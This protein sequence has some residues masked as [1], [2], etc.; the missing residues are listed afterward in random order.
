M[1]QMDPA[2]VGAGSAER[3]RLLHQVKLLLALDAMLQEGSVSGAAAKLDM[4]TSAM[5]RLLAELRDFY[6][7]RIFVR[8][9][10][11]MVPTPLAES[12]RLRVRALAG[13]AQQLLDQATHKAVSLDTALAHDWLKASALP[14]PVL[15]VRPADALDGAPTPAI[16]SRRLAAIGDDAQPLRRLGKYVA[17][18]A[19]G[20][21]GRRPLTL[22]EARDALGIILAGEADP[23]QIGALL[24]TIQYRGVTA[25]ELAGFVEAIREAMPPLGAANAKVPP[26]GA[27]NAKVQPPGAANA[28]VPRIGAGSGKLPA[29][30]AADAACVD[31]DWPA[32]LSPN[33]RHTP[34]FMH[35]ARLVAAAG[36]RVL[37]HGHFGQGKESGKLELAASD[38]GIPVCLT[39]GEAQAAL[40]GGKLA[41]MPMSVFAAQTQGL[42]G[43]YNVLSTR[44]PISQAVHLINP[45]RAK[46][47]LLGAA[48]I[49]R[50][51]FYRDVA[52][53]LKMDNLAVVGSTRDFAQ[54]SPTRAAPIYR[55]ASGTDVDFVVP[56][57]RHISE[58]PR[59]LF[60][61]R[62]YWHALWEGRVRDAQVEATII[63]TAAVALLC[64]RGDPEARFEDA[65]AQAEG[66]WNDRLEQVRL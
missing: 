29:V 54:L 45:L 18:V 60:T 53:L 40:T 24:M 46:A 21:G 13:E 25:P 41:Y 63:H 36:Y 7:D 28:K 2:L 15:A 16:A 11:G 22:E 32:Y 59:D 58:G 14:P 5:S 4:Q 42:L 33:W 12:L 57:V 9:G 1:N 23:V 50:R 6:N 61:Q 66:L 26:L 17:T 64:V 37:L 38:A 44:T 8:T 48:K 30:G 35:A 39:L 34:W 3:S 31:L 52:R 20:P 51:D 10:R 49:S 55:I 65:L 47:T 27:A 43:L 56:A 62:E 19:P